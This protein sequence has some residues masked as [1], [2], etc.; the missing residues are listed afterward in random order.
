DGIAD[1]AID[2]GFVAMEGGAIAAIGKQADLGSRFDDHERV[3]LP[4]AATV[5]PGLV[6]CHQHLVFNCNGTLEEQVAGIDDDA[7]TVRA[8]ESAAIALAAGVTTVRD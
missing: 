8:R 4:G 6:H 1:A 3:E 2:R 5:L 7:L